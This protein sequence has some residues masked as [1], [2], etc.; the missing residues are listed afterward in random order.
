MATVES[1]YDEHLATLGIKRLAPALAPAP[2][3]RAVS[4]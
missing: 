2:A 3:P 4:G 1:A